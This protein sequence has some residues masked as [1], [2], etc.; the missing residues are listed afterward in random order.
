[1][2]W[3]F[4]VGRVAG[5][6]VFIHATFVLLL[7]WVGVSAWSAEKSPTAALDSVGFLT[8]LFACVL[9]HEFG[10]AITARRYR[11]ATSSITLLP[12][13]GVAKM[14]RIPD[15][16]GQELRVALAGP[17]VNVGIAFILYAAL[18]LTGTWVPAE[19]F[20]WNAAP[21]IERL[22]VANVS[23]A[24][25]NL[26][27][28]FPMD[29][30]RVLRAALASRMPYPRATRIAANVGQ[31]L[32][33]GL[34]WLGLFANPMLVFIALFVWI[35]AGQEAALVE[36]RATLG[37][38]P[39]QAAMLTDFRVLAPE[40]TLGHAVELLLHGHQQDFPVVSGGRLAGLLTR[41]V[42]FQALAEHGNDL[43]VGTAMRTDFATISIEEPLAAAFQK[44]ESCDCRV[45]PVL[46]GSR[47]A[48]LL[49]LENVT[50]YLTVRQAMAARASALA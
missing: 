18:R 20:D 27:P 44:L 3:S 16:P 10:H 50:E 43:P 6:D 19:R 17:L 9:L 40:E 39:L 21:L 36:A 1:M 15:E 22:W 37:S 30:G 49:T 47:L 4:K 24:V 31:M 38:A 32:A 34:A 2:T 14:E 46:D 26:I 45:I 12:I 8:G 7:A 25:F 5:I 11:I 35:G 48:G 23:L 41:P 42:L 13:G 29:G 28:A 33:F